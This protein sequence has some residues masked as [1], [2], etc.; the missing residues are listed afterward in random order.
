MIHPF[1]Y[2]G[3]LIAIPCLVSGYGGNRAVLNL[4]ID[5]GSTNTILKPDVVDSLGY[6]VKRKSNLIVTTGSKNEK[7]F[8]I[9]VDTFETLS[10]QI[11]NYRIVVKELPFALFFIDG[12]LG[13]DFFKISD[14]KLTLDFR[15]SEIYIH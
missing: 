8:D 14:K 9:T 11:V 15:N 12:L 4:A 13:L 2:R 3:G 1:V 5:T 6:K 7:A 10:N